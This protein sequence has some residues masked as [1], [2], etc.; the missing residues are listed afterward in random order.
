MTPLLLAIL[1]CSGHG[2][3]DVCD[4]ARPIAREAAGLAADL[5]ELVAVQL[6]Q[7]ERWLAGDDRWVHLESPA[8]ANQQGVGVAHDLEHG[9]AAAPWVVKNPLVPTVGTPEDAARIFGGSVDGWRKVFAEYWRAPS[10]AVRRGNGD[11]DA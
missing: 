9:S 6:R 8:R 10:I 7:V 3:A 5:L 1:E 2:A 4:V 11:P